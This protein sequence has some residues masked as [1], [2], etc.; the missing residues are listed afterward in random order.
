MTTSV[1]YLASAADQSYR[2]DALGY[3][4]GDQQKNFI[5]DAASKIGI[6]SGAIAGA[7]VEEATAYFG[8]QTWD[9]L[10]DQYALSAMDSAAT[11]GSLSVAL[12]AGLPGLLL[13]KE[14]YSYALENTR[15]SHAEWAADYA[16]VNG[17]VNPDALDKLL[18]PVLMDAGAANFKIYTAITLINTYASANPALGLTQYLG[19]Y[20][21]LAADLVDKT[22]DL[23]A[24]LYGLYLKEAED[25][26][27]GKLAYG[28]QWNSLP[29]EFK[30]ALLVSYTNVGAKKMDE[31]WVTNTNNGA[32]VPYQPQPLLGTGG[33]MNHLRNAEAIG[34]AIGLA[35]Y[36]QTVV[37]DSTN[38]ANMAQD[39]SSAGMAYRY[40]L[41]ELRYVALPGLDH[42][43]FNQN[44]ELDLYSPRRAQ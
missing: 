44:G 13:W 34:T 32:K 2:P 21:L 15:R 30:D 27:K 35:G 41:Q 40:A 10:L 31:L 37:S 1:T 5:I 6:S 22:S 24:K 17:D 12:A 25:W 38:F 20:D 26:F 23:T 18:H 3:I 4:S 43:Q 7:M 16:T 36:G 8:R 11:A 9:D 42:S 14:A 39:N 19:H 33:G 28:D 29:Q